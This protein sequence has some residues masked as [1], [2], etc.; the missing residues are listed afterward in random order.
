M[1]IADNK[2]A[3]AAYEKLE[4]ATKTLEREAEFFH[5]LMESSPAAEIANRIVMFTAVFKMAG[6]SIPKYLSR[7]HSEL[8]H[9]D[10]IV[11]ASRL[12]M[13]LN[14]ITRSVRLAAYLSVKG[15]FPQALAVMRGAVESIGVYTHVWHH[16][17]KAM[18][19]IDSDS[20]DYGRAF[21][22]TSDAKLQ[23][24]LKTRATSY[25]F[26]YCKGATEFSNFYKLLS[27][28]AVHGITM[29]P[30]R[31]EA[32]SCEFVDRPN[33][34]ELAEQYGVI[35]SLFA[36]LLVELVQTISEDDHLDEDISGFVLSALIFAPTLSSLPGSEDPKL[37][38]AVEELLKALANA[39]RRDLEDT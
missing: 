19:V 14:E 2:R 23:K 18:Y 17:E 16:P 12:T 9:I 28:H 1:S 33:P 7:K 10:S 32:L 26:M 38:A 36:L 11:A 31:S 15:V 24:A 29:T 30:T 39:R 5:A 22:H 8:F 34:K 37:K 4:A 25:R 13:L 20:D 35:Q 27:A 6:E 3:G 21:R